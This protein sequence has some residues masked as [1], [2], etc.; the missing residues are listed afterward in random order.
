MLRAVRPWSSLHQNGP[1]RVRL[2]GA[3]RVQGDDRWL[4]RVTSETEAWHGNPVRVLSVG[5]S[6]LAPETRAAV[7]AVM[8]ALLLLHGGQPVLRCCR[9]A[10]KEDFTGIV[11]ECGGTPTLHNAIAKRIVDYRSGRIILHV[12]PLS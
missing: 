6:L 10:K 8:A 2:W 5:G 12:R 9:E 7:P 4:G 11:G 3:E 1:V